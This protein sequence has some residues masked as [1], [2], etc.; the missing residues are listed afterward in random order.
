M[1]IKINK[2][3]DADIVKLVK[4]C[5]YAEFKDKQTGQTSFTHRLG[6]YFYPRFHLYIQKEMPEEIILTLHLDQK[7]PSYEGCPAHSGEY[8]GELVEKEALRIKKYI[9]NEKK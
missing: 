4:R 7:R 2:K 8:D 1:K 5:G 3:K 9:E 6:L